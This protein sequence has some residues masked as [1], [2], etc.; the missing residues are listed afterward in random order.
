M[1]GETLRERLH[2]FWLRVKGLAKRR[3]LDRDPGGRIEVPRLD[4]GEEAD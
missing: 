2:A 3:E 4:A 1:L